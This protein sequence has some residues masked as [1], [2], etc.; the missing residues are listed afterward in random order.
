LIVEL[1]IKPVERER[2]RGPIIWR[3]EVERERE[4]KKVENVPT[5]Q[6]DQLKEN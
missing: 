2:K 3:D 6:R 5:L 1:N 4:R